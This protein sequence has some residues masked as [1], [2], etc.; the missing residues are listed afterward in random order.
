MIGIILA[1]VI[2]LILLTWNHWKPGGCKKTKC[3]KAQS[4]RSNIAPS[5]HLTAIRFY[6]PTCPWC[7]RSQKDWDMFK[8]SVKGV[9]NI[10]EY[11]MDAG[12]YSKE[13]AAL[14]GDSVPYIVMTN[15]NDKSANVYKGDR[16]AVSLLAWCA[17]LRQ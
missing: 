13:L 2:V 17:S 3:N 8:D 16:S 14:G 11:N 6:R 10:T 4:K 15:D 5:P 9:I 12:D 1:I 7:V